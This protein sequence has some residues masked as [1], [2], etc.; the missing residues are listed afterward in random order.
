MFLENVLIPICNV[1]EILKEAFTDRLDEFKKLIL[2][3]RSARK[4]FVFYLR[5]E[6]SFERMLEDDEI[7]FVIG[8][9]DDSF[10]F[11][12]LPVGN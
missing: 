9:R 4:D 5:F 10:S 1:L 3:K 7:D 6:C 12:L 2:L 11:S 8:T